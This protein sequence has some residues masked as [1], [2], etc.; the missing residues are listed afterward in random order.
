MILWKI[1]QITWLVWKLEYVYILFDIPG[2]S[3][4]VHIYIGLLINQIVHMYESWILLVDC[5]SGVKYKIRFGCTLLM[6]L[7]VSCLFL[8]CCVQLTCFCL[9]WVIITWRKY[10]C[11]LNACRLLLPIYW[12][13]SSTG[14]P[15]RFNL[16]VLLDSISSLGWNLESLVGCRRITK[17]GRQAGIC[18]Y[19]CTTR[20]I[21]FMCL[22]CL[23]I[24]L[25]STNPRRWRCYI[26]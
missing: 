25:G 18:G 24:L 10:Q 21:F 16:S 1:M 14:A 17:Y 22:P 3:D 6:Y 20:T 26:P 2:T 13:V 7:C 4:N 19:Q 5:T 12:W 15:V 11:T 8:Y 9:L 23:A